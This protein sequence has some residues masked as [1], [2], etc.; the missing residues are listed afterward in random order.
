MLSGVGSAAHG[1][2]RNRA[3]RKANIGRGNVEAATI[4]TAS[5]AGSV[6]TGRSRK[7][8]A[9]GTKHRMDGMVAGLVGHVKSMQ[10]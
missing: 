1:A 9:K 5:V 6:I 8:K 2:K 3:S 10:S 4:G 7:T